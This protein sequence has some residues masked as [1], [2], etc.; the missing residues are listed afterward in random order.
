M[1]EYQARLNR[2][3]T[4]F[5]CGRPAPGGYC[6][7]EIAKVAGEAMAPDGT[8]LYSAWPPYGLTEDPPGSA[9]WRPT[10]QTRRRAEDG[11]PPRPHGARTIANMITDE[12][13]P[14][15]GQMRPWWRDCPR[16]GARNRIG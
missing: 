1:T 13:N 7:G 10:A 6:R 15:T 9:Y 5:L 8:W 2:K 4:R 3:H 11:R 14:A 12:L 16:C